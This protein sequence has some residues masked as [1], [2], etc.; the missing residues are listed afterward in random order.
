MTEI[1]DLVNQGIGYA[2]QGLDV[3]RGFLL[4]IVGFLPWD[5]Q[6]S[7]MLLF[8]AVSLFAGHFITKRFVTR[9]FQLPYLIWFL[10]IS[11]SIFLNL[12]YL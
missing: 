12:L 5:E 11:A 10:V 2:R 6:L 9:P 7:L 3:V 4:K 8:L 1:V